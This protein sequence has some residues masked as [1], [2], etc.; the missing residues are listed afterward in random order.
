M[1]IRRLLIQ[2][3]QGLR[4]LHYAVWDDGRRA[5]VTWLERRKKQRS[6]LRQVVTI[7]DGKINPGETSTITESRQSFYFDEFATSLQPGLI[8]VTEK[9]VVTPTR[10]SALAPYAH[11]RPSQ[12]SFRFISRSRASRV[13]DDS[14]N[15]GRSRSPTSVAVNR[16][17]NAARLKRE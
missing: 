6:A 14:P 8:L 2:E 4:N 5:G 16:S 3:I 9:K 12:S 7:V 1:W 10:V 13:E 15:D 11:E 17:L